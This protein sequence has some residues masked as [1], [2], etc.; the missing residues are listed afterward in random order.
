MGLTPL[1]GLVMGT[2]SGD[3]DP[4]LF[5]HLSRTLGWSLEKI[6]HMLNHDSGLLGLSG[7]SNDMRSLEQASTQG[8]AGA[9]LAIE[10]FCYRLA[11]SLA[12]MSCALPRL[13]GLIFTGGIG[14]N[15]ALVRSKTV[16]HL[17]LLNLQLDP[18]ANAA[19]VRGQSGPIELLGHPRVLVIAT[20]EERQIALDTLATINAVAVN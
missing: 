15:S 16:A 7:L 5:G 2:R 19:C 6:E 17:A 8:H 9:S 10:V 14:E 4:N 18:V 1:E 11:K 20:N 13:D 12:A 3:V